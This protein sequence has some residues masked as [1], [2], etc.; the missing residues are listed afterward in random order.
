MR[1]RR[2]SHRNDA[3]GI[4]DATVGCREDMPG[5][6]RSRTIGCGRGSRG[7][8]HDV[9][10]PLRLGQLLRGVRGPV[11]HDPR[12]VPL[13]L[14]RLVDSYHLL[15]LLRQPRI[16]REID[17]ARTSKRCRGGRGGGGTAGGEHTNRQKLPVQEL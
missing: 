6:G 15:L 14:Q 4:A 2:Q 5:G 7:G 3:D 16:L 11:G 1:E 13:L 17:T 12:L 9:Q 10:S 8:V